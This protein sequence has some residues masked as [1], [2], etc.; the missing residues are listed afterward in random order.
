M[1]PPEMGGR[2]RGEMMRGLGETVAVVCLSLFVLLA[3]DAAVGAEDSAE[4]RRVFEQAL[5]ATGHEYFAVKAQ[6]LALPGAR[7]ALDEVAADP[8][9]SVEQRWLAKA[10]LEGSADSATYAHRLEVLALVAYDAQQLAST[11]AI[12]RGYPPVFEA[13]PRGWVPAPKET[14]LPALVDIAPP[15]RYGEG[16]AKVGGP[17]IRSLAMSAIPAEVLLKQ[18]PDSVA[19]L[20]AQAAERRYKDLLAYWTANP[21][22]IP[23]SAPRP[24]VA[25]KMLNEMRDWQRARILDHAR[26]LAAYALV[27]RGDEDAVALLEHMAKDP[28]LEAYTG[29]VQWPVALKSLEFIGT[30]AAKEALRRIGTKPAEE[31]LKRLEEKKDQPAP[32]PAAK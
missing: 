18:S 12:P 6:I 17:L 11:R 27:L 3:G 19:E 15:G 20:A 28:A 1:T 13:D 24:V 7:K 4:I 8:K 10:M 9:R 29:W 23:L 31:A 22:K 5:T 32:A 2:R 21:A 25:T 30:D 14:I 16:L 26:I